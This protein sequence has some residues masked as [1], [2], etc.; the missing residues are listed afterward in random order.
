MKMAVSWVDASKSTG[1]SD[2][3]ASKI[4]FYWNTRSDSL[5]D[6]NLHSN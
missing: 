2:V 1:I 4:L 6:S 3:L 5:E